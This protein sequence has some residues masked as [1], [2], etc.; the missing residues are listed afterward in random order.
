[1]LR[2]NIFQT[3]RLLALNLRNSF[4]KKKIKY[5]GKNTVNGHIVKKYVK[6]QGKA[7]KQI[8]RGQLKLFEDF[9]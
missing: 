2:H 9:A 8:Y 1:M 5:R 3:Y 7:Y 6:D 4:V